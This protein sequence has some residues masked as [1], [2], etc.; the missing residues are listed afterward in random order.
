[1]GPSHPVFRNLPD[2]NGARPHYGRSEEAA[3]IYFF[4]N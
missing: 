1:M 3:I 4:F 2:T